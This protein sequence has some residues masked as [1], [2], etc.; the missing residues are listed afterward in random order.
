[1][2]IDVLNFSQK[3]TSDLITYNEYFQFVTCF[4]LLPFRVMS[5]C[6]YI[7][8]IICIYSYIGND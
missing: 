8:R 1:M 5:R 3:P 6:I 2:S 4:C 7:N